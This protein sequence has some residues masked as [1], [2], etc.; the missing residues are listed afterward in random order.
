MS[1]NK[2]FEAKKLRQGSANSA[3]Q[4]IADGSKV[5]LGFIEGASFTEDGAAQFL[6][7]SH[8][9]NKHGT[10]YIISRATEKKE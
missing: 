7:R 6:R 5:A 9:P 3:D 10:K 2:R 8:Q 1:R 4:L